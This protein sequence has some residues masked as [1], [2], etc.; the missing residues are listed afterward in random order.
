MY[1][2][3]LFETALLANRII[4]NCFIAPDYLEG[5]H[6]SKYRFYLSSAMVS[7]LEKLL[8]LKGY[9][10]GTFDHGLVGHWKVLFSLCF[11]Y[12]RESR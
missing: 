6:P 1:F 12:F 4:W 7:I 5:P 10:Q 2:L 11:G 3:L 9:L 8:L